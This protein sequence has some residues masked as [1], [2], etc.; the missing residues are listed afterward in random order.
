MGASTPEARIKR[1][2]AEALKKLRLWYFFPA[3]GAFGRAGI[4][5]II[6][7]HNGQFIGIEC[8]ADPSKKPTALQV[9]CGQQIEA[10]GGKWFLIRSYEDVDKLTRELTNE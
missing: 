7:I 3:S 10:A 1:R 6:T 8:K 5:D 4:P 2:V 9:Q